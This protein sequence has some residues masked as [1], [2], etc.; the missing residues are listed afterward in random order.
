M[1]NSDNQN[2]PQ[3][4]QKSE[5]L[6]DQEIHARLKE[7]FWTA[8]T[9]A[10]TVLGLKIPNLESIEQEKR[11]FLISNSIITFLKNA[12]ETAKLQSDVCAQKKGKQFLQLC[13]WIG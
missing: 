13:L 5:L 9:A 7:D 8:R 4:F 11:F 12:F 1:D 10:Y 6:T 3:I 2:T